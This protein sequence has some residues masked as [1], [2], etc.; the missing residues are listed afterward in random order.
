V[1]EYN[2][3]EC[4][5]RYASI[6]TVSEPILFGDSVHYEIHLDSD[7]RRRCNLPSDLSWLRMDQ[8][9]IAQSPYARSEAHSGND[10]RGDPPL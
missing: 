9:R 8:V 5:S 2:G 6:R 1:T 7:Y 10:S 4:P 3:F